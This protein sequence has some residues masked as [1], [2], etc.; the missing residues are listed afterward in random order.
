VGAFF[1]PD[2]QAWAHVRGYRLYPVE[3]TVELLI[4]IRRKKDVERARVRGEYQRR[5]EDLKIQRQQ[6]RER[7]EQIR[8]HKNK[9]AQDRARV[10]AKQTLAVISSGSCAKRRAIVRQA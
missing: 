1:C 9:L 2:H 10:R 7:I 5:Q 3:Q 6:E 8:Q 4:Q